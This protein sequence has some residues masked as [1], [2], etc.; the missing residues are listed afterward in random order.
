LKKTITK[1]GWWSGSRGKSACLAS[2]RPTVETT[3]PQKKKKKKKIGAMSEGTLEKVSQSS[4][5]F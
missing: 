5:F 1:N 2:V 4:F 3:V